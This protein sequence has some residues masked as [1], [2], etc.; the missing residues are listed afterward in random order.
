MK[1]PRL[2]FSV[3]RLMVAVAVAAVII[4]GMIQLPGIFRSRSQRLSSAELYRWRE[5]NL[6]SA[7]GV[8]LACTDRP[9]AL[10]NTYDGPCR[11]CCLA[12]A[13]MKCGFDVTHEEAARSLLEAAGIVGR[14]AHRYEVGASTPW[15]DMPSPTPSES[16][17]TLALLNGDGPLT[18]KY[19]DNL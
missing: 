7:A 2:R 18:R 13:G 5:S 3:R 1:L 14:L 10:K 12:I 8:L 6:R 19:F 16:A 4:A 17:E 15:A 11:S 9:G